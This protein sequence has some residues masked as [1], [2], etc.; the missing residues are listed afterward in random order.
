MGKTTT[1][2]THKRPSKTKPVTIQPPPLTGIFKVPVSNS[3]FAWK[4]GKVLRQARSD[5]G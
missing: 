3:L 2:Q 4:L 1:D 5:A